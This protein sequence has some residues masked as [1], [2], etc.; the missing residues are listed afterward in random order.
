MK[1][2]QIKIAITFYFLFVDEFV[3]SLNCP[4]LIIDS[5]CG[6]IKASEWNTKNIGLSLKEW[7]K[8]VKIVYSVDEPEKMNSPF[9]YNILMASDNI[10]LLHLS[11]LNC[12]TGKKV[13][14]MWQIAGIRNELGTNG[15]YDGFFYVIPNRKGKKYFKSIITLK[16]NQVSCPNSM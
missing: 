14:P 6:D 4:G 16:V 15:F 8:S 5:N 1:R 3:I 9:R 13:G 11:S 7:I 12:E 10:T 2:F